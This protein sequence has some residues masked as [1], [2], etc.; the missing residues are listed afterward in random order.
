MIIGVTI[1]TALCYSSHM[2]ARLFTIVVGVALLVALLPSARVAAQSCVTYF[3]ATDPD[4]DGY[5]SLHFGSQYLT[6]PNFVDGDFYG[7]T[8]VKSLSYDITSGVIVASAGAGTLYTFTAAGSYTI[9]VHTVGLSVY[10][11]GATFEGTIC[12]PGATGTATPIPPTPTIT[13]TPTN[14]P[15]PPTVT[16]TPVPPTPTTVIVTATPV[17]PSP[18]PVITT[19]VYLSN[20]Q[21]LTENNFK[22]GI[23]VGVV[24]LGLGVVALVRVH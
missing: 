9:V 15:V 3:E 14:T 8:I 6:Y 20:I 17:P 7:Y 13:L 23:F 19:E 10:Q 16:N 18:T 5:Y 1:I 24:L 2:K 22:W 12:P 11:S 4:V 21:A